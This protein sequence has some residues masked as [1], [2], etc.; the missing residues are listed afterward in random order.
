[1]K[2][3]INT[4]LVIFTI[5][6]FLTYTET[7]TIAI[8]VKVLSLTL[9]FIISIFHIKKYEF[10][11]LLLIFIFILTFLNVFSMTLLTSFYYLILLI[12]FYIAVYL[13][14]LYKINVPKIFTI[15]SSIL[16]LL[17]IIYTFTDPAS[18]NIRGGNI[19]LKGIFNNNNTLGQL[20]LF[21]FT[22]L[23]LYIFSKESFKVTELFLFLPS[24]FLAA[25]TSSRSILISILFLILIILIT[26]KFKYKAIIIATLSVFFFILFEKINTLIRTLFR[27]ES[28]SL[29]G[30]SEDRFNLLKFF[31]TNINEIPLYGLGIGN[32]TMLWLTASSFNDVPRYLDGLGIHNTFIQIYIE[33]GLIGFIT[34]ILF[35]I[36]LIFKTIKYKEHNLLFVFISL[37][38]SSFFESNIFYITS[39]SSIL[40]WFIVVKIVTIRK[41]ENENIILAKH[42]Q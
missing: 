8:V 24:I 41:V 35:L 2:H 38:I 22:S 23:Y 30:L 33:L 9:L 20:V 14:L 5:S 25:F 13:L 36:F 39:P 11:L 1:M 29:T 21:N 42:N 19:A 28:L 15:V 12:V 3:L 18:I 40:F 31:S 7:Y 17:S 6:H 34:F 16:L 37:I 10:P 26:K 32:Q 27:I 4:L